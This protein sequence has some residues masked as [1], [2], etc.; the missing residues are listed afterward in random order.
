MRYVSFEKK[1]DCLIVVFVHVERE[2]TAVV[3]YYTFLNGCTWIKV[4]VDFDNFSTVDGYVYNH[5]I[6]IPP[7][8]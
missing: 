1:L 3:V 4:K 7:C 2:T 8:Q 6:N 5:C